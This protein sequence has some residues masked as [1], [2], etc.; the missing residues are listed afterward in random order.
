M[1][2]LTNAPTPYIRTRRQIVSNI[3]CN[4][5]PHH[6]GMVCYTVFIPASK[7]GFC[8]REVIIKSL[9]QTE[10]QLSCRFKDRVTY[11]PWH[12]HMMTADT[13][14]TTTHHKGEKSQKF[15]FFLFCSRHLNWYP[16]IQ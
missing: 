12:H 4:T 15:D 16:G 8:L 10:T 1:I 14:G 7:R 5:C 11:H 13:S 3:T 6:P 9:S 2:C